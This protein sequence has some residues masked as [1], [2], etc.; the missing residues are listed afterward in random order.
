M[1]FV[2]IDPGRA[3]DVHA[4]L[5][6]TTVFIETQVASVLVVVAD[7]QAHE[8]HE[9]ALAKDDDVFE[10]LAATTQDPA[11]CG[12]VLPRASIRGTHGIDAK[13]PDETGDGRAKDGVA[14]EGR[15]VTSVPC[16]TERLHAAAASP[17]P[18]SDGTWR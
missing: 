15:G 4:V 1:S 2:I 13:R 5:R 7:I 14:V 8:S 18:T 6:R 17:K 11:L 3:L 9:M 16:R 12:S 10:D